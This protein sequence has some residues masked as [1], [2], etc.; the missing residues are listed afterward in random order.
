MLP[1]VGAEGDEGEIIA[2]VEIAGEKVA[3]TVAHGNRFGDL[4]A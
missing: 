3:P 1:V 2:A 4:F